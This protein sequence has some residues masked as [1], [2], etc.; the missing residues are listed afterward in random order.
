MSGFTFHKAERL[1]GNHLTD[2][3]FSQ[4]NRSIGCFPVRLVWLV[5][6]AGDSDYDM[7][8]GVRLL[9]S[10]PKR[11]FKHAVDR[12]RVKRQVREYYRTHSHGLKQVLADKKQCMLLA[13]LFTDHRLWDSSGLH[14]RLDQAF[15]RL[16]EEFEG[17]EIVRSAK[18]TE[19]GTAL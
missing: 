6:K 3:L 18:E 1:C 15:G 10:A 7:P 14:A 9:I 11:H 2:R 19:P 17:G 16:A 4:G 5:L 8:G 13:V 12:N